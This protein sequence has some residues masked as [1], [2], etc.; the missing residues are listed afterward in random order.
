M[1]YQWLNKQ[2]NDTLLMFFNGW[3][4]D[5]NPVADIDCAG[6]DVLM[7]YDYTDMTI[8]IDIP[9]YSKVELLAWSLGVFAAAYCKPKAEFSVALNGTL[10][11]VDAQYGIPEDIFQGTIDGW[12]EQ[13]KSK[14]NRR[15]CDTRENQA[16]FEAHA[17]QRTEADQKTEL[18]A[19]KEFAMA[20]GEPENIF[21]TAL[22]VSR[23]RIIPTDAQL[24]FWAARQVPVKRFDGAHYPFSQWRSWKELMNFAKS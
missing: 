18:I 10:R 16:M 12:N 4:M 9:E 5:E 7:F 13:G 23:D 21:D 3:G 8:P 14:F 24:A 11:P 6:Y 20:C 19:I 2:N 22:A 1:K 17:P 15:M